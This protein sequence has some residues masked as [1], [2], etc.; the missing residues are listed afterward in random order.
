MHLEARRINRHR[1]WHLV[2]KGR[3]DG[4]PANVETS[5]LARPERI[6]RRLCLASDA[7]A[8]DFPVGGR[9]REI[10]ASATLA[11]EVEALGSGRVDASVSFSQLMVSLAIQRSVAPRAQESVEQLREWSEGSS[12]GDLFSRRSWGLDARCVHEALSRIRSK[13]LEE[14][15]A[16]ITERVLS[17]HDISLESLTFDATNFDSAAAPRT[18]SLLLRRGSARSRRRNL[19]ILG[20]GLL[21]RADGALPLLSCPYPASKPDVKS[22]ESFLLHLE[23]RRDS[24]PAGSGSTIAFDGG[25]VSKEVV[26][27]LAEQSLHLVARLP[28]RHP[29]KAAALPTDSLEALTGRLALE[30]RAKKVKAKVYGVARTAVAVIS[31]AKR[32]A[33]RRFRGS[34]ETSSAP[35]RN[36]RDSRPDSGF[37]DAVAREGGSSPSRRLS[38]RRM[39]RQP[40]RDSAPR[41][42]RAPRLPAASRPRDALHPGDSGGGPGWAGARRRRSAASGRRRARAPRPGPGGGAC[43]GRPGG[44]H[45]PL[46]LPLLRSPGP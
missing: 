5:Y 43:R 14:L 22:F 2:R 45:R 32:C 1:Y 7:D 46:A 21:A 33:A 40:H 35:A 36:W 15:G 12:I 13:D 11:Q 41:P 30:V 20:L 4:V 26:S 19:R 25:N 23:G 31:E 17:V 6:A 42:R 37:S 16:R 39:R 29:P 28:A 44:R 38:T 18:H 27:R 10:G 8:D 34:S 24:P 3:K 9:A